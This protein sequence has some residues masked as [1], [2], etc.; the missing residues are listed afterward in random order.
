MPSQPSNILPLMF[1]F[2]GLKATSFSS[3]SCVRIL[4]V[5]QYFVCPSLGCPL[6][7]CI[8]LVECAQSKA[9]CLNFA[10]LLLYSA[11]RYCKCPVAAS[12]GICPIP[13]SESVDLGST[14]TPLCCCL[15]ACHPQLIIFARCSH[16]M[17][18]FELN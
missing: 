8:P 4:Q 9:Q 5:F 17:V 11:R 15:I 6:C 18:L 14:C 13:W 10:L 12:D 1:C 16:Y 3:S 2:S 7:M